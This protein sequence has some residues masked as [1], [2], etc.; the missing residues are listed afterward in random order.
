MFHFLFILFQLLQLFALKP[1]FVK[2]IQLDMHSFEN[3]SK[4]FGTFC[5]LCRSFSALKAIE[6]LTYRSFLNTNRRQIVVLLSFVKGFIP[7][8]CIGD[9]HTSSTRNFTSLQPTF[10]HQAFAIHFTISSQ[11]VSKISR[12]NNLSLFLPH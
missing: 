7:I 9:V 1:R 12:D 11:K 3:F 5:L 8:Q 4:R 6:R 10:L 2:I